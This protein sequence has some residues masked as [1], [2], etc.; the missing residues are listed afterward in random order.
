L[1][2]TTIHLNETIKRA[3]FFSTLHQHFEGTQRTKDSRKEPRMTSGSFF[4]RRT[5]QNIFF[6]GINREHN[7]TEGRGQRIIP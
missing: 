2:F 3:G 6:R 4:V 5:M 1:N 7:V